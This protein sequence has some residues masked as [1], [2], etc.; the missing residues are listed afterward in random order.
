M[1]ELGNKTIVCS[2]LF[3]NIVEYSKQSVS[4]QIALKEVF[5]AYLATAIADVPINDRIVLDTGDGA[6]ISFL[7]NVES[8]LKAT[9]MFRQCL[10]GADANMTPL[11][12]VRMGINLGPVRLVKDASGMPNIVGDGINVAQRVME[13]SDPGQILVSRTYYDAISNLSQ[14]YAGLFHHQGSRT[15]KHVR[16]HEIYAIGYP[17]EL[18]AKHQRLSPDPDDG[19]LSRLGRAQKWLRVGGQ[20]TASRLISCVNFV[21]NAYRNAPLPQ[22]AAMIG[23]FLVLLLLTIVLVGRMLQRPEAAALPAAPSDNVVTTTQ[24][25]ATSTTILDSNITQHPDKTGKYGQEK[26]AK[27]SKNSSRVRTLQETSAIHSRVPAF[28]SIAV[29]PWGEIY[30]DGRMQGVS[31]PLMELQVVPGEHEIEIRNTTFPAYRQR[32]QVQ[33]NGKIKIKHKFSN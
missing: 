32:F 19:S 20:V 16:E 4:G 26:T 15:D 5:N 7:E 22:R 28:V 29:T 21:R 12:L 3:L 17:G 27:I 9:Q 2:V 25:S 31:P 14:D 18:P 33:A 13:F 23:M 6:V 1:E 10:L 30:L 24:S 8:A 11:L